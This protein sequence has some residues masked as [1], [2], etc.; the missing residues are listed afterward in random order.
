MADK[1][2][3]KT[4]KHSLI[5]EPYDGIIEKMKMRR[6][7]VP[8]YYYQLN[9]EQKAQNEFIMQN[10]NKK[11]SYLKNPRYRVNNAPIFYAD[12]LVLS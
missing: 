1:T 11:T 9:E 8:D 4:R 6:A 7:G 2:K 12:V 3:T 5:T 10:M